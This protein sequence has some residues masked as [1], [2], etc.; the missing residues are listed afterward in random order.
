MRECR[1]RRRGQ[2]CGREPKPEELI[3]FL[4]ALELTT[5]HP[6][7]GG[8]IAADMAAIEPIPVEVKHWPPEGGIEAA[9][10]NPRRERSGPVSTPAQGEMRLDAPAAS[11]PEEA[12]PEG[13]D[14]EAWLRTI[15]VDHARYE[16]VTSLAVLTQWIAQAHEQG[17]VSF[18]TETDS[19]DAMQANL[20]GVSL[21][22]APGRACYVPLNHKSMGE[23]LFGGDRIEGQISEKEALAVLVPLLQIP[24]GTQDRSK[25]E[26]RHAADEAARRRDRAHR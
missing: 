3:G 16:T 10:D 18:D 5:L 11:M 23:G 6:Q 22:L 15:P 2:L 24:F 1:W 26:I 19:L 21:A 14:V 25:P 7:G 9:A 8:R 4:K 20:V 12:A 13:D 17:H